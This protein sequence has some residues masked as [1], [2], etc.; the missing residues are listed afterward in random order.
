MLSSL[1]YFGMAVSAQ[2]RNSLTASNAPGV[3][4][5]KTT[6]RL[7]MASDTVAAQL[8]TQYQVSLHGTAPASQL[9]VTTTGNRF[10]FAVLYLHDLVVVG[11]D[12]DLLDREIETS[13]DLFNALF[14]ASAKLADEH[15][16][17][18]QLDTG[19]L[20][21]ECWPE[22]SVCDNELRPIQSC[23]ASEWVQGCRWKVRDGIH[24]S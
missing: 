2:T 20:C 15:R 17:T 7:G 12:H 11:V 4:I 10:P 24:C 23:G 19:R 6:I 13:D 3:V 9:W 5:G 1:L 18:C 21:P 16:A 22:Q 14:T 8:Q